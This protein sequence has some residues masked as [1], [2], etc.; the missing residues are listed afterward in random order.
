MSMRNC[1]GNPVETREPYAQNLRWMMRG[2]A[3]SVPKIP[4]VPMQCESLPPPKRI[5]V[6]LVPQPGLQFV[7]A[8]VP[9][10]VFRLN[11]AG[12]SMSLFGRTGANIPPGEVSRSTAWAYKYLALRSRVGLLQKLPSPVV[13]FVGFEEGWKSISG[14]YRGREHQ[15]ICAE[16]NTKST[17]T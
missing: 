3:L 8:R 15:Q 7:E 6:V 9:R 1:E 5:G 13:R 2:P 4:V 12:W 10:Q 17:K 14:A 11:G 16:L